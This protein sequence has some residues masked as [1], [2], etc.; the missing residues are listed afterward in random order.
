MKKRSQN[1]R[2]L[3][4]DTKKAVINQPIPYEM[5]IA[6]RFLLD[7]ICHDANIAYIKEQIDIALNNRDEETF[8]TYSSLYKQ[9][10]K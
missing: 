8:H 5:Q 7:E 9:Y 10:V 2:K 6:A 1:N 3:H 4:V